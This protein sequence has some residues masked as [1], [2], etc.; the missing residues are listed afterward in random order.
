MN[1]NTHRKRSIPLPASWS[2]ILGSRTKG[3][4]QDCAF[5]TPLGL[6]HFVCKNFAWSISLSLF[7]CFWKLKQ[8]QWSPSTS[9]VMMQLLGKSRT[10][11]DHQ[12]T[13]GLLLCL[14]D[15]FSLLWN[16]AR[17]GHLFPWLLFE[18]LLQQS[19]F[20]NILLEMS[21]GRSFRIW[22]QYPACL[23][24]LGPDSGI[25]EINEW[26]RIGQ[27][28]RWSDRVRVPECLSSRANL[29]WKDF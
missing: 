3:Y 5:I 17:R 28:W 10:E 29:N 26:E 20:T 23:L 2:I 24:T 21:P 27:V 7:F 25:G 22:I 8:S 13:D 12:T 6:E 19:L 9:S 16:T 14:R 11:V 4:V 1:W 15:P 18:R